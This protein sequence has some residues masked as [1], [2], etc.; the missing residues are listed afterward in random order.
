[1]PNKISISISI[2]RSLRKAV[3]ISSSQLLDQLGGPRPASVLEHRQGVGPLVGVVDVLDER[4]DVPLA[5]V[6]RR[7]GRGLNFVLHRSVVFR[8]HGAASSLLASEGQ[9][10]TFAQGS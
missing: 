1:M 3:S 10:L 9:R 7:W 5:E 6:N 2:S 4:P 8:F